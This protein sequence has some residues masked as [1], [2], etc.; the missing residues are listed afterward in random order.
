MRDVMNRG[1]CPEQLH[2]VRGAVS[3]RA[4]LVR[5]FRRRPIARRWLEGWASIEDRP[6]MPREPVTSIL[7]SILSFG[8]ASRADEVLSPAP[9]EIRNIAHAVVCKP[10]VLTEFGPASPA[11]ID[12]KLAECLRMLDDDRRL[13][14]PSR[15]APPRKLSDDVRLILVGDWGDSASTRARRRGPNAC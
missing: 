2:A 5:P 6:V 8:L 10:E 15:P 4:A 7:Q 12:Q 1:S 14:P 9:A 11:Y 13:P 3:T